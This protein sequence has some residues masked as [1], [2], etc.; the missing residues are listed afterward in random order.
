[1]AC[2]LYFLTLRFFFQNAKLDEIDGTVRN[3]ADCSLD[4]PTQ[5]LVKLIFD[6]D[7]FKEA[8]SAFNIGTDF[9]ENSYSSNMHLILHEKFY[10]FLN[11]MIFFYFPDVKKMPLGKLSKTQI[12]KGFEC[13]EDI[14]AEIE[15][16]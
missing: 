10:G 16:I 2:H 9:M 11:I 7:M 14:Q 15:G 1:M 12:A 8:M 3:V 5:D 6:H 13:L 4:K